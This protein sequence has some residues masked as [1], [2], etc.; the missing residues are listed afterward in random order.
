VNSTLREAV[1]SSSLSQGIGQSRRCIQAERPVATEPTSMAATRSSPAPVSTETKSESLQA[2]ITRVI[3]PGRPPR[4]ERE[5]HLRVLRL[6]GRSG[7]TTPSPPQ[8]DRHGDDREEEE[9]HGSPSGSTQTSV[10]AERSAVGHAKSVGIKPHE[11]S[12]SSRA[13]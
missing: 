13:D 11:Q 6:A 12:S 8:V 2:P 9:S 7:Q 5:R 1:S 3:Q 4:C 10:A